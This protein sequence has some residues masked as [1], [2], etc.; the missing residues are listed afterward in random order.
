V[1][2]IYRGFEGKPGLVEAAVEAAVA[3]G[4]QRV[5][6]P[7]EQRPAIR[8]VIDEPDPH[9]KLER[10]AVTQPGIHERLGPLYRTLAEAAAMEPD[11][12]SIRDDELEMQRLDGMGRFAQHCWSRAAL[13]RGMSVDEA[14]DILWSINSHEVRRM[15]VTERGWSPQQYRD[16]LRE[17]SPARCSRTDG[18]PPG[19]P[20]RG[21]MD[22]GPSWPGSDYRLRVQPSALARRQMLSRRTNNRSATRPD[23]LHPVHRHDVGRTRAPDRTALDDRRYRNEAIGALRIPWARPLRAVGH[24]RL[25]AG[26]TRGGGCAR[27]GMGTPAAAITGGP[28]MP[29]LLDSIRV[30]R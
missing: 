4:T 16:W 2:T 20:R 25:V 9:R 23:P 6:R 1:E 10:Y 22:R 7:V 18:L 19:G 28:P 27:A 8:A 14:R 13:R 11:L 21:A 17:C 24:G 29:D 26:A 12:E 15:L 30:R 5:E 3:G